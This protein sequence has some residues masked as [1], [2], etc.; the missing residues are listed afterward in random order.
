[1]P[2]ASWLVQI[3]VMALRA[4]AV[5]R[6]LRPAMLPESSM[7]KTVS[8]S[9]RN[10]YGESE[11]VSIAP[12]MTVPLAGGEYAGGAS[13]LCWG[14]RVGVVLANGD[15]ADTGAATGV[16]V[17]EDL[18][19]LRDAK[20]SSF[21]KGFMVVADS[22]EDAWLLQKESERETSSVAMVTKSSS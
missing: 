9:V 7:R 14:R 10:A 22:D 12:G 20:R 19:D 6:Q 11:V 13:V 5:S 15:G 4:A 17:F 2:S 21:L 18:D 3:G 8:N 1:M 16:D